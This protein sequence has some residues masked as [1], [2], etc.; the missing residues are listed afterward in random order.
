MMTAID[1]IPTRLLLQS[2]RLGMADGQRRLSQAQA[3]AASGRHQ[4]IG[5]TL[6]NV[7]GA[8]IGLRL[9]LSGL[10]QSVSTTRL[11]T[12]QAETVQDSLS[13]MSGLADRFRST[14]TGARSSANGRALSASLAGS[15]ID[16]FR[17]SLS[18]SQ[19]GQYLFSGLA[20]DTPPINA[21]DG[22]PRQAVID[23]FQ[24]AFGFAP[25]DPA[26][27]TLT[28]GD[29]SSFL[30]S[31]CSALFSGS[32]WTS[33]WSN[34]ADE[35]PKVRLI[36]GSTVNLST[37]ANATFAKM[38]AEGFAIV[39]VF[40]GSKINATAFAAI[41]DKS[42]SLISEA[43]LKIGDEQARIGIGQARLK[44]ALLTLEQK[45]PRL[46]EAIS[47]FENI[48]PYEAAT[49]VNLLMNQ[50]ESSYALTGRI[51]RMNLLSYL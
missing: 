49:R 41:T 9:H 8:D 16:S 3:E 24:T 19:N 25:D 40:G 37:S 48:D 47:D 13:E 30:D 42:L 26:A 22:G 2:S 34:A 31:T 10:E 36:S 32:S 1:G 18:V 38:L 29:I 15:S 46:T 7:M 20:A 35:T 23:A 14:L 28:A 44:D 43:Q 4:D 5:L 11:L 45:K 50:L 17:D 51:S 39:E 27:A 33:T 6:G 12:V 21:Y